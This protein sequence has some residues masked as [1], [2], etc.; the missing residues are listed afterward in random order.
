M[1]RLER[2]KKTSLL[3]SSLEG[4]NFSKCQSW[5]GGSSIRERVKMNHRV[6][7]LLPGKKKMEIRV[8]YICKRKKEEGF[9]TQMGL[10]EKGMD[11]LFLFLKS[12][13]CG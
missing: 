12:V 8:R 5:R 11:R 6:F 13:N 1:N 9:E 4:R 10:E 2:G 7:A 3:E